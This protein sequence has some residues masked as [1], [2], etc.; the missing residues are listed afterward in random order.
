MK[1]GRETLVAVEERA[2]FFGVRRTLF[3][4]STTNYQ[5]SSSLKALSVLTGETAVVTQQGE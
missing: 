1:K 3:G 5:H 2:L 4:V